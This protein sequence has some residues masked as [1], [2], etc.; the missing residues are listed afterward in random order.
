MHFVDIQC[1]FH[2]I[3]FTFG[4]RAISEPERKAPLQ[5]S[6]LNSI[7][8]VIDLRLARLQHVFHFPCSVQ[9][10]QK[11][12]CRLCIVILCARNRFW[13][14]LLCMLAHIFFHSNMKWILL[15]PEYWTLFESICNILA[16]NFFPT[17]FDCRFVFCLH[18]IPS[19]GIP[20]YMCAGALCREYFI[21]ALVVN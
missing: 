7:N 16:T 13:W 4:L 6:L 10:Q 17:C 15:K 14:R 18:A 12:V 1:T 19:F 9:R 20:S 21:D 11:N 8:Y 5:L 2:L 3:S